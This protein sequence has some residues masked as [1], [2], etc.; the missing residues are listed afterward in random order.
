MDA[1]GGVAVQLVGVEALRILHATR[2]GVPS[3]A[4]PKA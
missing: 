2:R 4:V 1:E 3:A